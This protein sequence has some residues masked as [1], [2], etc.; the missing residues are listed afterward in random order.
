M[1]LLGENLDYTDKDFDSL[2]T[3]LFNLISSVFPT[4]T[5]RQVANFG[6]L[7][8][9][10][11]AFVGDILCKYQDNQAI[12][13]RWSKATQRK[14]LIALAK[15]ISYEPATATASQVDVTI[16]I[17]QSVSADTSFPAGTVVRTQSITN[18]VEFQLLSEAIIPAGSTSVTDVTAENSDSQED[19]FTSTGV[20][21][22]SFELPSTPYI[23]D[24]VVI[25]AGNGV[26]TEVDNFLDSDS[27]DLHY[28]VTVDQNDKARVRFGDGI[29]GV[30]PVGTIT[31]NYKTGGG[32]SGIVEAGT[33]TVIE[34]TFQADDGTVVQASVT[35][36]SASTTSTDRET[37]AQIK[38]LAPLSLRVLNRTVSREDYEINALRVTGVS[39]AL[40]LTSDEES[41]IQENNGFL[42]IIPTGGGQPTQDLKDEVLEMVTV[43]YPNTLTFNLTVSGA[44]FKTVDVYARVRL[45]NGQNAT[46]VRSRIESNLEDFFAVEDDDGTA[47]DDMGFGYDFKEDESDN[48]GQ[49]PLSDVFNVV[50]DTE[51]VRKIVASASSFTLNGEYSDVELLL[52]EFPQLGTVTLINDETGAAL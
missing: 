8:V 30:I 6:N 41:A 3:R 47:N 25:S 18:P 49:L 29:N 44:S 16:S 15:L 43:T 22:I 46:T 33:V 38:E 28:T 17:T 52:R 48:V 20:P 40:M 9:E 35:N 21:N 23:D 7:L 11:Y 24:S 14:N 4:W 19:V 1:A 51:G 12:E 45:S 31:V 34:G 37:V 10:M 13:S 27:T 32:T 2:R 39:R 26:Y 36:P 42:F 5:S 50:R